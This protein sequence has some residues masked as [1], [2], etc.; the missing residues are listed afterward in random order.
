MRI[1]NEILEKVRK[2]TRIRRKLA[3][4]MDISEASIAR[5]LKENSDN[6][7]LTKKIALITIAE[8]LSLPENLIIEDIIDNCYENDLYGKRDL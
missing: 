2:H 3:F 7:D 6:G 1:R 8:G 5:L 4:R